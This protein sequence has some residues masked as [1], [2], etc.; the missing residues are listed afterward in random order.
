MSTINPFKSKFFLILVAFFIGLAFGATIGALAGS[1]GIDVEL[2]EQQ[3]A[4]LKNRTSYLEE[5]LA[6]KN[7]TLLSLKKDNEMLKANLSRVET[8]LKNCKSELI[9]C[10][11]T[12]NLCKR[13]GGEVVGFVTGVVDAQSIIT[14]YTFNAREITAYILANSSGTFVTIR[15]FEE[16]LV[17]DKKLAPPPVYQSI[18]G[19]NLYVLGY[20]LYVEEDESGK[21]HFVSLKLYGFD[22]EAIAKTQKVA[23]FLDKLEQGIY[24]G[25]V[26]LRL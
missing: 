2:Y 23:L 25:K 6:L 16:Y 7:E 4:D 21:L 5:Q 10:N 20:R 18:L 22:E 13:F 1:R 9:N 11:I 15:H 24:L 14:I 26:E 17:K 8:E 12:L 19:L 3:I